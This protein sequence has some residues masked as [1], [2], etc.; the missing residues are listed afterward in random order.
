MPLARISL[1]RGRSAEALDALSAGVHAALVEHFE[2]PA[3]DRFQV[4]EQLA[5]GELVFDR[6]YLG[7]PRSNRFV[8]VAITAGRQRSAAV[9]QRFYQGLT[10]RLADAPGI[11]PED[12]MV[13]I[14]T[15]APEDWSFGGG[16]VAGG[17]GEQQ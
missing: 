6:D 2:V 5:P 8:L 13:V 14:S 3:G 16:R 15:G 10:R 1:L 17:A 9:K 11:D 4:I 7:G 12:V